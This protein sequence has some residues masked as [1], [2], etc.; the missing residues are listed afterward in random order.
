MILNRLAEDLGE[1][2]VVEQRPQQDGRNMTMMLGPREGAAAPTSCETRRAERARPPEAH[3]SPSRDG[4]RHAD[5]D[6]AACRATAPD[7]PR[8]GCGRRDLA[9]GLF[10]RRLRDGDRRDRRGSTTTS[11][12]ATVARRLAS[13][14]RAPRRDALD[15]RG[16][17][18]SAAVRRR[19]GAQAEPGDRIARRRRGHAATS[20]WPAARRRRSTPA[21][22][23]AHGDGRAGAH[24]PAIRWRRAT[25][26]SCL[27]RRGLRHGR[28]GLRRGDG[29]AR[30]AARRGS[31]RASLRPG[32]RLVLAAWTPRAP[33]RA[34]PAPGGGRPAARGRPAA[35]RLGPRRGRP[36]SASRRTSTTCRRAVHTADA[37][38]SR[39]R[40]TAGTRSPRPLLLTGNQRGE[41]RPRFD[42]LLEAQND[43]A[44]AVE[45]AARY[46]L[47]AGRRPE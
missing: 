39:P 24:G 8:L 26:P 38:R 22:L 17:R 15:G 7:A 3:R 30:R 37:A 35:G 12:I 31:S 5:D 28:L 19:G 18:R 10:E 13:T 11:V 29:A 21:T 20:R 44:P 47:V 6:D 25:R 45:L 9:R 36:R 23:A 43:G 41:L 2:A 27:R 32:G 1:L 34:R 16:S 33:R 14:A 40:R 42:A 4:C 46:L